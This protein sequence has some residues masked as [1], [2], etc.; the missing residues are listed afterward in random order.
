MIKRSIAALAVAAGLAVGTMAL[1][2]VAEAAPAGCPSGAL[3]AYYSGNYAGSVQKVYQNNTDLTP[4]ANFHYSQG[5]SLY[6]NGSTN[7]VRVYA[8]KNYSGANYELNRG[9]GWA[10]IGSNL[11]NIESNLWN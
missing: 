3:C 1:A 10:A 5:G 2:P 6:N 8:G 7:N 4:Y 11:P 9:S